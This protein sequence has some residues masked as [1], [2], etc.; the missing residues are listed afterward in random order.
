MSLDEIGFSIPLELLDP[1]FETHEKFL[2][3]V[4]VVD[5]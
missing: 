5:D 1:N 2:L 3:I 4:L